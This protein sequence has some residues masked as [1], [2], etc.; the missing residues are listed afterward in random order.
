MRLED[1]QFTGKI[2]PEIG[3]ITELQ[4]LY[5]SGNESIGLFPKELGNSAN[6][7]RSNA[8]ENTLQGGIPVEFGALLNLEFLALG[9]NSFSGQ[10]FPTSFTNLVNLS[11]LHFIGSGVCTPTDDATL[12]AWL[13]TVDGMYGSS[14]PDMQPSTT[15][16]TTTTLPPPTPEP[17][18]A[19]KP[20]LQ[21][22]TTPN[23]CKGLVKDINVRPI[24]PLAK[25]DYL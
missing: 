1:N 21:P 14:C 4:Y 15:P 5:L 2:P 18:T 8:D 16:P 9:Q 11:Y 25:P 6:L 13:A 24:Q 20:I 17:T 12:T 3:S 22:T 23:L 7:R 10:P 19:A